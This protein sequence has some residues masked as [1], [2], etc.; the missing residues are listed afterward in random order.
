M[1]LWGEEG[2]WGGWRGDLVDGVWV[3]GGGRGDLAAG[4]RA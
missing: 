1:E 4:V 3:D 2:W